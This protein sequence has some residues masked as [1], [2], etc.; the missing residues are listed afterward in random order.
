M[1]LHS[2]AASVEDAAKQSNGDW[3]WLLPLGLFFLYFATSALLKML[4][5][6]HRVIWDQLEGRVRVKPRQV[7]WMFVVIVAVVLV[8][9]FASLLRER[10]DGLGISTSL[11]IMLVYFIFW[12]V[13]SR[14]LPHRDVPWAALVPGAALFAVGLEAVYLATI[15]WIAGKVESSSALYGAIGV[16]AAILLW[17]YLIGRV[18]VA[19]AV[20]NVTLWDRK[21]AQLGPEA[22]ATDQGSPSG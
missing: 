19:A 1:G 15:F 10:S 12:L 9:G 17:L 22:A 18:V 2:A 3:W 14:L 11:L 8:A 13:A 21:Q 7:G 4:N 5:L 20:L 6:A 16:A